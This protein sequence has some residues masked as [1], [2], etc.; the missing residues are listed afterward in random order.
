M[1]EQQVF[2]AITQLLFGIAYIYLIFEYA[3]INKHSH[4]QDIIIS[5]LREKVEYYKNETIES[6]ARRN[7]IADIKLNNEKT[8][9]FGTGDYGRVSG[10]LTDAKFEAKGKL[11]NKEYTDKEKNILYNESNH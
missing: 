7:H 1:D 9:L 5:E 11:D 3:K 8:M 2:S 6:R 10:I 4:K